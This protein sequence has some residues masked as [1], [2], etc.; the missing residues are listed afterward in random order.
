MKTNFWGKSLEVKP[1]GYQHVRLK[2]TGEHFIIERPTSSVNNLI[3]GEMYVE[4]HGT[5]TVK[6]LKNGDSSEIEFKK[7]GWGGKGANEVEGYSM[8]WSKEKKWRISGKWIESLFVKNLTTNEE[9]LLWVANPMP[10]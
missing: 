4:H 10:A 5:M 2:S 9:S 3:F 1:M 6:N 7:K 8:T